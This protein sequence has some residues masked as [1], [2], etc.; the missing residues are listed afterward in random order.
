LDI[1]FPPE[2]LKLFADLLQNLFYR[3]MPRRLHMSAHVVS[4]E[5]DKKMAKGTNVRISQRFVDFNV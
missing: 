3:L 5:L 1:I 2:V 4:R